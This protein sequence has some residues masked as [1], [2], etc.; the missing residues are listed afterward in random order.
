MCFKPLLRL[1]GRSGGLGCH[2]FISFIIFTVVVI[3]AVAVTASSK[4][5]LSDLPVVP[6]C[7]H[8]SAYYPACGNTCTICATVNKSL[9]RQSMAGISRVPSSYLPVG[10]SRPI[11]QEICALYRTSL[12][13]LDSWAI[14][15]T[16]FNEEAT[17]V[18]A[19]VGA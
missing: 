16:I 19:A 5:E 18:R 6:S 8:D 9:S 1:G 7:L 3:I 4:D 11:S 12:R 13:L 10:L 15:R 2:F 17:K 14:D